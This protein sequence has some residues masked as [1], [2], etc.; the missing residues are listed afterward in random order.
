MGF[1]HVCRVSHVEET[2]K[3]GNAIENNSTQ[4]T[5]WSVEEEQ[6]QEQE[7]EED[8]MLANGSRDRQSS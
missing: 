6:E 8:G 3:Y 5:M 2:D 1:I 4:C 7:W